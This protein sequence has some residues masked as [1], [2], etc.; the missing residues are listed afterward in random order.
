MS[1][2]E[3]KI[4]KYQPL[5]RYTP[6]CPGEFPILAITASN[7]RDMGR[8]SL[9]TL[10]L[11]KK[12]DFS[13]VKVS[14]IKNEYP[15]KDKSEEELIEDTLN[16]AQKVGIRILVKPG[17]SSYFLNKNENLFL[18]Y[19]PRWAS[20]I[21]RFYNYSSLAG[22]FF[23]DEP[24][25][26]WEKIKDSNGNIIGEERTSTT[27]DVI[28][29]RLGEAKEQL[30]AF[31]PWQHVFC[32]NLPT[33]RSFLDPENG[34]TENNAF[35]NGLK[36][37]KGYRK[38]LSLFI[39]DFG[40]AMLSFSSYGFKSSL[41]EKQH[42]IGYFEDLEL[43]RRL[44]YQLHRPL[45][46]YLQCVYR[47]KV[48]GFIQTPS[49][50]KSKNYG[51]TVLHRYRS[52]AFCA[53]AFG[54]QAICCWEI[55]HHADEF[56]DNPYTHEKQKFYSPIEK[57]GES[58]ILL[59]YLQEVI[60]QIR[61]VEYVFQNSTVRECRFT[62]SSNA[63]RNFVSGKAVCPFGPLKSFTHISGQQG[64]LISLIEN[65]NRTYMVFVNLNMTDEETNPPTS[66]DDTPEHETIRLTFSHNMKRLAVKNG[67]AV[68]SVKKDTNY[69]MTLECAEMAIFEVS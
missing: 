5:Q 67:E 12:A 22:W 54:A 28:M 63:S 49:N 10:Q 39:N 14:F 33:Y 26:V 58:S 15:G 23:A 37:F 68:I 4:R 6:P 19:I 9:E 65:E 55:T 3:N 53:L 46:A 31:D 29:N 52:D 41:S 27:L 34:E 57:N 47:W 62:V 45:W 60:E 24:N 32:V 43:F 11:L 17:G 56:Y 38:Y 8:T 21:K 13:I 25:E 64:Y 48:G 42:R 35:A 44:S 59:G 50:G 61:R 18:E 20:I 69:T 7:E 2:E 36:W 66:S 40:P 30:L 16:D 1:T 51:K